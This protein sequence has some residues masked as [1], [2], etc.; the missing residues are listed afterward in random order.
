VNREGAV[1]IA[2]PLQP[3]GIRT[4]VDYPN[5]PVGF[6]L[7]YQDNAATSTPAVPVGGVKLG[8]CPGTDPKCI[9]EPVNPADPNSVALRAGGE[10]FWWAAD[11]LMD[12]TAL[13]GAPFSRA[14]LVLAVEAFFNNDIILD[15]NQIG[16]A[17]RR[18]RVQDLQQGGDYTITHPYGTEVLTAVDDGKGTGTFEINDTIDDMIVNTNLA[19][20]AATDNAFTGAL[21][22]KIGPR[23]LK[24]TT[25]NPD[26]ALNDPLLQ[27]PLVP[28][29]LSRMVMYVGDPAVPHAVTGGSNGNVFRIQGGGIDVQTDLFQVS[30]MVFDPVFVAAGTTLPGLPAPV[31]EVIT[32]A[33][34]RF[35]Q[36]NLQIDL[37]GTSN[38][39]GS[40]L[41]IHA[42]PDA[43]GPIL[44]QVL[45]DA[46]GWRLRTVA[47][48][49]LNSVSIVSSTGATLLN[50]PVQVR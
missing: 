21:F 9:S 42:G 6:P 45:V 49:N 28:G 37:S 4:G 40:T 48:T 35:R 22:G 1:G 41:V 25:F 29:D 11:A 20:L 36:R 39:I 14:L 19:N 31:P 24:W 10:G 27:R 30:G 3:E 43:S 44:G 23:F 13:P 15:G 5:F 8:Y 2:T 32:I 17:R 47:T 7:W 26:P 46:G 38:V 33:K 12:G 50:Q 18:I 16:F 34:A